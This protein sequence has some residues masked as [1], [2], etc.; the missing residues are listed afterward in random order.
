VWPPPLTLSQL[1]FN[2]LSPYSIMPDDAGYYYES[3]T[4]QR[5]ATGGEGLVD[6]ASLVARAKSNMQL[7]KN[8]YQGSE[9]WIGGAAEGGGG[10]GGHGEEEGEQV[11]SP[12]VN[13]KRKHSTV[14]NQMG[15]SMGSG[16]MV[17]GVGAGGGSIHTVEGAQLLGAG[18]AEG[19][20]EER[21]RPN[22]K[23]IEWSR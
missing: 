21:M 18:G 5:E 7:A 20:G 16:V 22:S 23:S 2:I 1:P 9:G 14:L 17:G 3:A 19:G 11:R 4:I 15:I 12:G 6:R 10:M 13:R 8:L